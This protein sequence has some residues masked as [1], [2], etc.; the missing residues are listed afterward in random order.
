[1]GKLL[2]IKLFGTEKD[3]DDGF[4]AIMISDY[5]AFCLPDEEYIVE[6]DLTYVLNGKDIKYKIVRDSPKN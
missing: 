1:M 6:E 4:F 2:K 3:M 5:G